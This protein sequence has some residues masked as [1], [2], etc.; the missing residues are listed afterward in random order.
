VV[1]IK[2]R[3]WTCLIEGSSEA[4]IPVYLTKDGEPFPGWF[5][6]PVS[7]VIEAEG[8]IRPYDEK[9]RFDSVDIEDAIKP[10]KAP[11]PE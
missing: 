2:E 4:P 5:K 9:P 11:K 7:E 6:M 3:Y 10:E 8:R 1:G